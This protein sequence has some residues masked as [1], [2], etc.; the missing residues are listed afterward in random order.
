MCAEMSCAMLL[1]TR[2]E[3]SH[4][5]FPLPTTLCKQCLDIVANRRKAGVDVH[6]AWVTTVTTRR[7]STSPLYLH[8]VRLLLSVRTLRE[9]DFSDYYG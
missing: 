5:Q 3:P 1:H 6:L 8:A 7:G 4:C 9:E 2:R